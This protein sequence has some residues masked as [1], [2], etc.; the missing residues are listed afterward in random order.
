MSTKRVRGACST[1]WREKEHQP[2]HSY[3]NPSHDIQWKQ[4][5][6]LKERVDG[7]KAPN[8]KE[9][10]PGNGAKNVAIHTQSHNTQIVK[11]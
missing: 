1:Q 4:E 2:N 5:E 10:L 3:T 9:A 8:L 7:W 11:P 6:Y